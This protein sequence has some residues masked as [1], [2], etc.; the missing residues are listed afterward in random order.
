[1]PI[2][3]KKLDPLFKDFLKLKKLRRT[4]WQLRGIRDC[5]SLADHC[6]GVVFLTYVLG[7]ALKYRQFDLNRAVEMA[8]LH[9]LAECRVGDIPFPALEFLKEKS[10]AE[11]EAMVAIFK[12]LGKEGKSHLE[13]FN[14]FEDGKSKEAK[15]VRAID[16]L[17]MLITAAEYEH[18]GFTSLDDFWNNPVTFAAFKPFPELSQYAETL[19]KKHKQRGCS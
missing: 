5:E 2:T 4:G 11:R 3:I 18:I 13:L 6:F 19:L 17:E 10:E 8:I 9:E 7:K 12:P 14:E 16:K 1:M 15:F